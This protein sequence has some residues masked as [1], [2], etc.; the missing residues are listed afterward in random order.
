MQTASFNYS[1]ELPADEDGFVDYAEIEVTVVV[2]DGNVIE[3]FTHGLAPELVEAFNEHFQLCEQDMIE[4]A[5]A[6]L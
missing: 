2:E 1:F 4:R 6:A 5:Y 3:F